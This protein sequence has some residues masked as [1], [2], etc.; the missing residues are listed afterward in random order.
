[1]PHRN[2]CI[3]KV[4]MNDKHQGDQQVRMRG[5]DCAE[6]MIGLIVES[7]V[8]DTPV[9]YSHRARNNSE[10]ISKSSVEILSSVQRIYQ[11][12]QR[13][14]SLICE[15]WK[16]EAIH[17]W[18]RF[19]PNDQNTET[20]CSILSEHLKIQIPKELIDILTLWNKD[21]RTFI[22]HVCQGCLNLAERLSITIKDD[23]LNVLQTLVTIDENILGEKCSYVY[24]NYLQN[25]VQPYSRNTLVVWS[26]Y[27]IANEL[28]DFIVGMASTDLDN[29]LENVNDW[30]M[31]L[32]GAKTVRDYQILKHYFDQVYSSID[33]LREDSQ[34]LT[35]PNVFQC[36]DQI[37]MSDQIGNMEEIFNI[38]S[39]ELPNMRQSHEELIDKELSKR[40]LIIN[41]MSNSSVKFLQL[42][43]FNVQLSIQNLN[44]ADLSELRDR[45][46]LI[47]YSYR[48]KMRD[49]DEYQI[50]QMDA[51]IQFVN[52]IEIILRTLADLHIA[53]YPIQT[54]IL[55]L[56]DEF[57]CQENEYRRLIE[58]RREIEE[59]C[60]KWEKTLCEKYILYPELTY[61][62]CQQFEMLE[63]YIYH[64]KSYE[65]E[66]YGY[67]L[68]KYIGLDPLKT[69]RTDQRKTSAEDR[70]ETLGTI[71]SEQRS[72]SEQRNPSKTEILLIEI[73]NKKT[74]HGILSLCA[75]VQ[76]N[77]RV[78]Q[79][80]YCSNE[81]TWMDIRGF[82]YRCFYSGEFH[83][84]I[85]PECL[86][87]AIQ[88]Q[89]IDLIRKFI[90]INPQK[91][92]SFAILTNKS[93]DNQ[94]FIESLKS[95]KILH[96]LSDQNLLSEDNFRRTL[97]DFIQR[98]TLVTSRL[99]G[100]GKSHA[101]IEECRKLRKYHLKIPISGNIRGDHFAKRLLKKVREFPSGAI[102]FDMGMIENGDEM[103]DLI[104]CLI[105]FRSF[106]FGQIAISIPS[107]MPIFIE[108]DSS[109]YSNLWT[110]IGLFEYLPLIHLDQIDW[111][112]LTPTK[113]IRFVGN[114]LKSI[115]DQT[116]T[117]TDLTETQMKGLPSDEY[118][119]LIREFF[120]QNQSDEFIT[121]NKVFIYISI[122][123]H[124]FL[125]FSR[126]S[127]FQWEYLQ[128]SR[129]GSLRME[130]LQAFLKS[131]D[132][133]TSSSIEAV[134]QRKR[135][136]TNRTDQCNQE[137]NNAIIRWDQ[138]QPFTLIF[139]PSDFPIFVYKTEK[140]V[141]I[142]LKTY[143]DLYHQKSDKRSFLQRQFTTLKPDKPFFPDYRQL[144]HAEFFEKLM[145]LLEIKYQNRA[146]C[147]RCFRK[148]ENDV[149]Y[150]QMCKEKLDKPVDIADEG[151]RIA[152]RRR[153]ARIIESEYVLTADNFIKMLLIF[154][155]VQSGVPVLI[156]G[157]TGEYSNE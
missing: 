81:T 26:Q 35:L 124:L 114:Y 75:H 108:L 141:P 96:I 25:Y 56:N 133:F 12:F 146:I 60:H 142:S 83:Q 97:L 119:R 23:D 55:Q 110:Q 93:Q 129:L 112:R 31:K 45:A 22:A 61:F 59:I 117:T 38:C 111:R 148:Y 92:F 78:N 39:I 43:Q 51:F 90:E 17:R 85:R 127:Y 19:F 157:E 70:L 46:R 27:S 66:Q 77:P 15:N 37:D 8:S 69:H 18:I 153:I 14:I 87:S 121:W 99:I 156:M 136:S 63:E 57:L 36:Y 72:T 9:D 123:Y 134:R 152:F 49:D 24:Q 125:G 98:C 33:R 118:V 149:G 101:I 58:F 50:E 30:G 53:G 6:G 21:N 47:E 13:E 143:F 48:N 2:H 16:N 65:D 79:L 84:L 135:C 107:T 42:E 102:H 140:D 29:L 154:L 132:Q 52:T 5:I 28:I 62:S 20:E 64:R 120:F 1:M 4:M 126:C 147:I 137:L 76:C 150:C 104:N 89:M 131:A 80:F 115:K 151:H 73:D 105:L 41:I 44:F 94:Q 7:L 144:T 74:L 130:I 100:L 95:L 91:L 54:D 3:R 34:R 88:D 116:I 32:V 113:C 155:R 103:S 106:C 10:I 40:R 11:E 138:L 71:L 109:T 145:E 122:F 68:L 128:S 82:V 139:S 86:S 67:H